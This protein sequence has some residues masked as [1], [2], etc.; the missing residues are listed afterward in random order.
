MEDRLY[1]LRANIVRC[2]CRVGLTVIALLLTGPRLNA[3]QAVVDGASVSAEA[4]GKVDALTKDW[5]ARWEQNILG[6]QRNRYC[7]KEMGEE[8]GWTVSPFLNGFCTLRKVF[9]ANH[10]PANWGG[11]SV[12]PWYLAR[13]SRHAPASGQLHLTSKSAAHVR[14]AL[15]TEEF[16][17]RLGVNTHLDGLTH[18]DPWNTNVSQVGAQLNYIG[19]RLNRDWTHSPALGRTWKDVQKA[20]STYG[21]FWTSI[22]E[23]GPSYQRRVLS[24]QQAI[25]Q[26]FPGLI[27]AMGGPNEEDDA[28]PQGQ[29]ATLPDSALVQQMLYKWAHAE[30]R[31]I[32]V[33][34]MEFG[35]GWT[36]ANNWQGDYNPTNTGIHQN[37]VPGPADFASA[38]TYLHMPGQRPTDV[39]DRLR[40]IANL[41]TPGKSVAHTEFGAYKSANFS[42]AT[43]GKYLITGAFDSIAAGDAAYIVY[44]LQDSAPENTYGFFSYPD[45]TPHDA[46]IYFHT[47]TTLLKSASGSYGPGSKPTFTPGSL[48]VSFTNTS[49]GHLVMQKPAGEFVIAD[50]SEQLMNGQEHADADTIDFGRSFA[51]VRV[52]DI[53]SGTVPIAVLR[54]A[55]RTTLRMNP[56]DT[57]LIVLDNNNRGNP[58]A[59]RHKAV[60]RT[61]PRQ[62][63]G[64][65]AGRIGSMSFVPRSS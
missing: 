64:G 31:N 4:G 23:G 60:Q 19:V 58:P 30:G 59:R 62:L 56:N 26:E 53:E 36:A 50:W 3:T 43:F 57:Y 49:A 12:T 14:T 48:N 44:G 45:N 16:L 28:Y 20:W 63:A 18:E 6:D 7:D 13:E 40:A 35:A 34:Q 9:E 46:A 55:S 39:L 52:Y 17:N 54:N 51:T 61:G 8:I 65:L 15:S 47:L 1:D 29:G 22:D 25:Y 21:R 24:Y 5:E 27:Y 42:A 41:T 38:H 33:S 10:N 2:G 32:P 37:Y 11:L